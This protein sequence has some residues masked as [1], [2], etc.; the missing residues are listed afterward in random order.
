M[1][2]LVFFLLLNFIEISIQIPVNEG[3]LKSIFTVVVY[4]DKVS[5]LGNFFE[6]DIKGIDLRKIQKS[7]L[8]SNGYVSNNLK[9]LGQLDGTGRR[10]WQFGIVPY[11]IDSNS[12]YSK[13]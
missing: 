7:I 9:T 8:L 12:N 6:G 11:I 13:Y 10:K 1:L 4:K 5:F 3:M 2:Y